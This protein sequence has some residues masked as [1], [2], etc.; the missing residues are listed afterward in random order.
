M[1]DQTLTPQPLPD[2]ATEREVRLAARALGRHGLAHAYGHCSKRLNP[3][4]FLVNSPH[5]LALVPAKDP[6][7]VVPVRGP[8]PENVLG[9]VRIHQQIYAARPDVGGIARTQPPAAITLSTAGLVP[10]RRHGFGAYFHAGIKFWDDPQLLRDDVTASKLASTL[11]NAAAISMRGNGVVVVSQTL[12]QACVL[13]WYLED[14]AR[15]EL[16]VRSS[17]L[18][19]QS[20]EMSVEQS[21]KRATWTGRIAE[22][23]WQYMTAGD[24]EAELTGD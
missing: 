20:S 18:L 14:A 19:S 1:S 10:S 11:G 23:M 7:T 22:R 8:L 21:E 3:D 13:T 5:P 9:E 6:G 12:K 15:L 24:V 17:G 4:Y 2:A 16:S